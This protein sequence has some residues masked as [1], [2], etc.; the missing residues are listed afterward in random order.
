MTTWIAVLTVGAGS[1]F[2]R[3]APLFIGWFA[4]PPSWLDRALRHA[5]SASL[6]ALA[7]TS[8]RLQLTDVTAAAAAG[9]IAAVLAGGALAVRGRPMWL[10]ALVGVGVQ[11]LLTSLLQPFA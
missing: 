2:F 1:Y 8:V 6:M 5:G 9:T 10:V 4:S 7:A 11:L 3:V